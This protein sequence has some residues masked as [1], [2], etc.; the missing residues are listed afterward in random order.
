MADVLYEPSLMHQ[1][2]Q[3]ITMVSHWHSTILLAYDS[4][5][6][7]DDAYLEF[8]KSASAH[9][10][11]EQLVLPSSFDNSEALIITKDT[12]YLLRLRYICSLR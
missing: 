6:R 4:M 12:I 11:L 1:L 5:H 8:F 10:D 7:R 3:T 9:F 2:V